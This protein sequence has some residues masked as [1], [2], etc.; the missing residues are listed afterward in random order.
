M[1]YFTI[2]EFG[3]LRNVN[4]NS[5]RYYEKIGIL[6]PDHVD[7]KTG[8]RYYSP[9]QL[10]ILDV[11]LL[12]LNFG[13]PLKELT[14]YIS[15][16]NC[17]N[18]TKLFEIGKQIALK[19]LHSAQIELEKIEYTQ[20]Y[21]ESNRQYSEM[22]GAYQR[23]IPGRTLVAMEYRGS[24]E[25]IRQVELTSA[26][27]YS[28]A[29]E[30][31][32]FPVFP[33]GLLL[34]KE[35]GKRRAKVFFEVMDRTTTD[36]HALILPAGTFLCHKIDMTPGM[37]LPATIAAAYGGEPDADVIVANILLDKFQIGTKKSEL[38]KRIE[39]KNQKE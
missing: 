37:D 38:Q 23:D 12:C 31:Q 1:Y 14:S 15:D 2:S 8:Y 28:Y 11:I 4:I 26:Q 22:E 24:L 6:K 21:V 30:K 13:M 5:L 25:D 17:I 10:P 16:D 36:P 34:Q 18:N 7:P 27:L 19:R 9:D 20:R 35:Q 39:I 32:L 33:A 3:K 29:Q